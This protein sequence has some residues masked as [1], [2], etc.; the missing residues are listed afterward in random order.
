MSTKIG[1]ASGDVA[2]VIGKTEGCN[3]SKPLTW[4]REQGLNCELDIMAEQLR[5]QCNAQIQRTC[6]AGLLLFIFIALVVK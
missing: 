6:I 4:A 5:M 1:F 3:M 2:A